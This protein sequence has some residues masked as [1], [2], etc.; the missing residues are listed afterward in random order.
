GLSPNN[1]GGQYDPHEVMLSPDES[2]YFVTCQA[3]NQVF[4]MDA[5]ADTLIK[6]I[7]VGTFPLEMGIS[8]LHN[9]MFVTC[10]YEPSTQPKTEGEVDVIDLN[11]LEVIKKLQDGLYEPHGIGVMD[12]E[13]YVVISSRNTGT[14]GPA[15][16][17]VSSCGGTNGFI[18]LIDLNTLE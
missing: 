1:F 8:K 6:K 17:H 14:N 10:E 16:H 7:D 12:D 3:A 11:T 4:V 15:P 13:G 5:R 9:E 18:K 2:K